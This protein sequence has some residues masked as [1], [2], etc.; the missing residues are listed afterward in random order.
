MEGRHGLF[1]TGYLWMPDG[2]DGWYD[3]SATG[4]Y[5]G[6]VYVPTSREDQ[7]HC[8]IYQP[9]SGNVWMNKCGCSMHHGRGNSPLCP[10]ELTMSFKTVITLSGL[11]CGQSNHSG[12][13]INKRIMS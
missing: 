6:Y 1:L 3:K 8:V 4:H 10:A 13:Q 11:F 9:S 5:D 2:R 7:R 12:C